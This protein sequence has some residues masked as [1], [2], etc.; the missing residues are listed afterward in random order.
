MGPCEAIASMVKKM[1]KRG[2]MS[3]APSEIAD[4]LVKSI[5]QKHLKEWKDDN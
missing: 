2:L 4:D 1:K 5:K 3:C